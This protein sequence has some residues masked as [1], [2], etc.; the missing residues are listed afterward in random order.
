MKRVLILVLLL[1]LCAPTAL[2]AP[3]LDAQLTDGNLY[4]TWS[5]CNCPEAILTVYRDNWP[6]LVTCVCGAEGEYA[7][8][9][10][11]TQD[12]KSTRLNSS[13]EIP[14]RMPSSA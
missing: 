7:V 11:Y 9:S 1:L 13:H 5:G 4:I 8:P 10:W 2:A 6:V 12:R 14:S 3:S